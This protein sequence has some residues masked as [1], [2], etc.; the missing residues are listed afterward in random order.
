MPQLPRVRVLLGL[1]AV[2]SAG[3]GVAVAP[4]ATADINYDASA[5]ANAFD[6]T[7][8]NQSVPLG[9]V[10]EGEG[11]LAQTRQTSLDTSDAFA[12]FPYPGDTAAQIPGLLG[13]LVGVAVPPYPLAAQT[14]NGDKPVSTSYPG[15]EL[16]AQSADTLTQ[17][18]A[19]VG[20]AASGGTS[21]AQVIRSASGAVSA[22]SSGDVNGLVIGNVL[23]ISGAH[24][25]AAVRR[26]A[27]GQLTREGHLSFAHL[28]VPGL[29]VTI[30]THTPASV[31]VP[32]PIPP[33]PPFPEIPLPLGGQTVPAPDLAFRDGQFGIT[34]PGLGST[35]YAV[36]AQAVL[37]GL[38]AAGIKAEYQAGR[39]T[40]DGVVSPGLVLTTLI[41]APP[42]N[43]AGI[44]GKSAV[45]LTFGLATASVAASVLP[46]DSPLPSLETGLPAGT[47]PLVAATPPLSGGPAAGF[48]GAL[49]PP[50]VDAAQEAPAGS[51]EGLQLTRLGK[52]QDLSWLYLLIAA[53]GLLCFGSTTIL[54]YLGVRVRWHS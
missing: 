44:S 5:A 19:V 47:E 30:P 10:L 40:Q 36:P 6:V 33:L 7:L 9:L 23:T 48:P 41:P 13:G 22:T 24:S 21:R 15:I 50:V 25:E 35:R 26:D 1:S 53:S 17:S 8:A 14:S 52:A 4:N 28:G 18:Q 31:P 39:K 37:D 51:F 38:A 42:D 54:R 2:L 11:P 43:P 20:S 32:L 29:E 45:T 49:V 16:A 34:L 3:L 46:D 27:D 12:A